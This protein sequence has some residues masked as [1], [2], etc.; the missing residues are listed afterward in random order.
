MFYADIDYMHVYR[1]FTYEKDGNF[2]NLP[3]LMADTK[4]ENLKWT[5]ILDPGIEAVESYEAFTDG[6]KNE[7]YMKW[8][9]NVSMNDRHNPSNTPNDKDVYYGKVWPNGPTAFPDFMKKRTDEWWNRQIVKF[10]ETLPFDGIWIVSGLNFLFKNL[11]NIFRTG[12]E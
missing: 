5:V 10:H 12:H 4:K 2:K 9:K 7:V 1:D 8:P 11:I 3:K 6:Y